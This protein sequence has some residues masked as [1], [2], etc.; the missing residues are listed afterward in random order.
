MR[1]LLLLICIGLVFAQGTTT[2]DRFRRLMNM[3]DYRLDY[4][5]L[6]CEIEDRSVHGGA[7]IHIPPMIKV[8]YSLI[9]CPFAIGD[10]TVMITSAEYSGDDDD[11]GESYAYS[12]YYLPHRCIIIT[13]NHTQEILEGYSLH[14][15]D[16]SNDTFVLDSWGKSVYVTPSTRNSS[17]SELRSEEGELVMDDVSGFRRIQVHF[18]ALS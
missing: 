6:G 4:E 2:V 9:W 14:R 7:S 18:D 16:Y 17:L 11:Y 5:R 15:L 8:E 13:Q 12:S 1:Q 10:G 3:Q